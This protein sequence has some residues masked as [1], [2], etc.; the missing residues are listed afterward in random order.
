[1][2]SSDPVSGI[3]INGAYVN[4]TDY[5][6]LF[7][8]GTTI[9]QLI[10]SYGTFTIGE[11]LI[12][13]G[14]IPTIQRQQIEGY[15]SAKWKIAIPAIHPYSTLIRPLNRAFQPVD[16]AGCQLWL[17]AADGTTIVGTTSNVTAWKD[18]SGLGNDLSSNQ[19]APQYIPAT[20]AIYL[21][22]S[23]TMVRT[24]FSFGLTDPFTVFIV[25][26][27]TAASNGPWYTTDPNTDMTGYFPRYDISKNT[28]VNAGG[29]NW[30]IKASSIEIGTTYISAIVSGGIT[31]SELSYY[32]NATTQTM[33]R[34]AVA[35]NIIR[36]SLYLGYR[37]SDNYKI[38]GNIYEFIQYNSVLSY[39]QRLQIEAYLAQK[40]G[41]P[42]SL[43]AL[44]PG[45]SL[46]SF[47]TVFTPKSLG[48]ALWLDAAD[49]STL[50]IV[51]GNVTAWVN[52]SGII[53]YNATGTGT[54]T[55]STQSGNQYV[56]LNGTNA[57]FTGSISITGTQVTSFAVVLIPN[58]PLI[59]NRIISL[60]VT[61]TDDYNNRLYVASLF[62]YNNS[63]NIT[64]Y[65][66]NAFDVKINLA[67]NTPR[68]AASIYDGAKGYVYVDGSGS[69]GFA[70]TG[71][72][73]ISA[74]GIGRNVY[75][76]S[77]EFFTGYIGEVL[78]YTTALTQVQRQQ[79][80]GYLA[81]KWGSTLPSTHP[82]AKFQP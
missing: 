33:S 56:Y 41:L 7:I 22:G 6:H 74:Y 24:S 30:S 78:I 80:E 45:C 49:S 18:K 34:T 58:N 51:S 2:K 25:S 53:S 77:G 46:P 40:W 37:P 70:S 54:P 59:T 48:P 10:G 20:N 13:D 75:P 3:Y 5:D 19:G 9:E 82:Y 43:P 21:D 81:W 14:A 67:S 65:R 63:S 69:D 8:P 1:M 32:E 79:V 42:T 28:Y 57:G 44:H 12:F 62:T 16:I 29:S 4:S 68:I 35:G 17:D 15:L 31:G 27:L 23:S 55:V 71:T 60:G 61:S 50:T 64:T 38:I 52:K 66:A 76:A 73:G 47:S 39:S 72:F 36:N 11:I 26:R